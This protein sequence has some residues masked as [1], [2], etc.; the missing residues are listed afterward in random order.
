MKNTEIFCFYNVE[1]LFDPKNSNL[2]ANDFAPN[3]D[4]N[5]TEDRYK[6][7]LFKIANAIK[8]LGE[9]AANKLP[10]AIGLCEVEGQD[11]LEDLIKQNSLLEGN[12][13]YIHYNSKDERGI[14][15]AFLYN[16]EKIS[17]IHSEGI[18]PKLE[19]E[20]GTEDFTRD[21]LYI[22]G[23]LNN[24]KVYFFVVHF[25]SKRENDINKPKREV[26][27]KLLRDK[28]NEVYEKDNNSFIVVMGDFNM[29]PTEEIIKKHI[30]TTENSEEML[31]NELFNPMEAQQKK[32]KGSLVFQKEWLLF[33][34]ILFSKIFLSQQSSIKFKEADVFNDYSLQFYKG[35]LKGTPYRTYVGKNY[36]GGYS[37]HFPIY[38]T[39]DINNLTNK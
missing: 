30:N 36:E 31:F 17:I 15:C 7:K 26:V 21:I 32:G 24:Q 25:P 2:L 22:V 6:K 34:Q 10:L 20:D 8:I 11:V 33:D 29:N 18:Q 37:D 3:S 4:K 9:S 19:N 38:A 28:I 1:N 12:Y 14:D 35:Y 23:V 5:W 13:G 16:K 27:A 39:V